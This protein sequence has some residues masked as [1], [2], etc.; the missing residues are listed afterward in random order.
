MRDSETLVEGCHLRLFLEKWNAWKSKEGEEV[1][2][3]R[4]RQE[5]EM[6]RW[7][8]RLLELDW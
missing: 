2:E 3:E 4:K 6:R 8:A 7:R 5:G 1:R